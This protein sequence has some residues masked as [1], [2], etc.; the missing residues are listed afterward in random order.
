MTGAITLVVGQ[1]V[2][3]TTGSDGHV[4]TGYIASLSKEMVPGTPAGRTWH[5]SCRGPEYACWK[6]SYKGEFKGAN[7]EQIAKA[8]VDLVLSE[9]GVTYDAASIPDDHVYTMADAAAG[10]HLSHADGVEGQVVCHA[11][12]VL[13][14]SYKRRRYVGDILDDLQE[15]SGREWTVD[16][17]LKLHFKPRTTIAAPWALTVDDVLCNT[18]FRPRL[19]DDDE[20]YRNTQHIINTAGIMNAVQSFHGDG[21]T[22]SFTVAM[23]LNAKPTIKVNGNKVAETEVGINGLNSGKAWYWSEGDNTVS[24]DLAA[25]PLKSSDLLVIE[26]EG[27]YEQDIEVADAA[28]IAARALV[29]GTGGEVEAV[30][31]IDK[32]LTEAAATEYATA[33][34]GNNKVLGRTLTFTTERSGLYEHMT[35][36]ATLPSLDLSGDDFFITSVETEQRGIVNGAVAYYYHVTAVQG[37]IALSW[38][39]TLGGTT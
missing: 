34:L 15:R 18:R 35:L 13:Q 33:E 1:K 37:P 22:K 21:T 38:T 9:D 28:E 11:D 19:V 4:F 23:P 12:N 24:Q 6:R 25:S 29:D 5:I 20:R 8:L 36:S 31:T 14:A 32:E 26:Y 16:K 10:Q 7:V 27:Q 30:K 3:V 39:R 2:Q 17:D